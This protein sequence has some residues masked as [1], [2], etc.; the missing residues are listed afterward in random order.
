MVRP[1][2]HT[3]DTLRGPLPLGQKHAILERHR[4]T[5]QLLDESDQV[6]DAGCRMEGTAA[7]TPGG[8]SPT[9]PNQ[10]G[11]GAEDL[12]VAHGP[13]IERP[14]RPLRALVAPQSRADNRVCRNAQRPWQRKRNGGHVG[15][16]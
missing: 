1:G 15:D 12:I 6:A 11:D 2:L 3:S 7:Y 14:E 5:A 13:I 8:P 9:D 10:L 4:Y 16:R